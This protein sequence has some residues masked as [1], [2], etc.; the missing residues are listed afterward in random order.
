METVIADVAVAHDAVVSLIQAIPDAALDWQPD[1]DWSLRQ[2][3]G[4]LAHANDFYVMIVDEA[5]TT[6]FGTI[7]LHPELAGWQQ[8]G[9][10]D[11]QIAQ[12]TTTHAVLDCFECTYQRM[13]KVFRG[14]RVEELDRPFVFCQP[15]AVPTTTTLRQRVIQMAADHIRE[16]QSH[17]SAILARW[18][19]ATTVRVRQV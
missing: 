15:K 13:L 10:T 18:N 14:L 16:H 2:I 12:C 6:H 7:Q 1:N 19:R 5:R 11:A 4:H 17:L 9:A 8:M 3:I